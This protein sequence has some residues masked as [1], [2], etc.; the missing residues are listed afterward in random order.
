MHLLIASLEIQF[1]DFKGL[2]CLFFYFQ[3]NHGKTKT[4]HGVV[5]LSIVTF[6]TC[7]WREP[8]S[9]FFRVRFNQN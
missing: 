1:L 4:N 5:H 9:Y 6:P 3:Q 2:G 8:Q 7:L